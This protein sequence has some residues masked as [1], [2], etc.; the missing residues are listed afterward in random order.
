LSGL[1]LGVAER[2]PYRTI[3][4]VKVRP[5]F[6]ASPDR[7]RWVE[8]DIDFPNSGMLGWWQPPAE[9][10]Q[11]KAW[12][13]Q[14]EEST[15]FDSTKD[16][17]DLYF[18]RTPASP[19]YELIDFVHLA[20]PEDIRLCL[21]KEG[22]PASQCTTRSLIFR[23][24]NG[25]LLGPLEL[26][27]REDRLL[28]EPRETPAQLAEM[29]KKLELTT[30]ANHV[31]MPPKFFLTKVGELDLSSDVLF[32][33]RMLRESR[34]VGSALL[35]RAKL[36][37]KQIS[38]FCS[39][40]ETLPLNTS[41]Q[42]R[43]RRLGQVARD[44]K[45]HI[46]LQEDGLDAL[47]SIPDVGVAIEQEKQKAR[48]AVLEERNAEVEAL[49]E[50]RK[51]L[52]SENEELEQKAA[53]L[54]AEILSEGTR[55]TQIHAQFKRSIAESFQ[56]A[57]DNAGNFLGNVALIKAAVGASPDLK[58]VRSDWSQR[59]AISKSLKAEDVL[60][61]LNDCFSRNALDPDG[62]IA[63]MSSWASG[64]VPIL[65]GDLATDCLNCVFD[66]LTGG[67][68]LVLSIPPALTAVSDLG[69]LSGRSRNGYGSLA[70]FLERVSSDDSLAIVVLEGLNLCQI[71]NAV[72]PLLSDLSC[73]D[74]NQ[75]SRTSSGYKH[76]RL[77]AWPRN[78]L[79]AATFVPSALSMPKSR[80]IWQHCSLISPK[81]KSVAR[82]DA[83]GLELKSINAIEWRRWVSSA[84]S[85]S[86]SPMKILAKYICAKTMASSSYERSMAAFA[87]ALDKNLD[88]PDQ[89]K[90]RV[91][92]RSAILPVLVTSQRDAR[93]LLAGAPLELNEADRD[94]V[95]V[96]EILDNS[97][98]QNG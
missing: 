57:E 27:L 91:L 51:Q 59:A 42:Q 22:I 9:A 61:A 21:T 96:I 48:Q 54:N 37:E 1:F 50:K 85:S 34:D 3:P 30:W 60:Q 53:R 92:L 16:S 44:L 26:V 90:L 39:V 10:D 65:E 63:L 98:P 43:L 74:H 13:F 28:L 15:T 7:T 18:V 35:D 8:P 45:E 5:L 81:R 6:Q 14:T 4:P 47:L 24:A 46:S 69:N 38:A 83:S 73:G 36:T 75:T 23:C 25:T 71:D 79:I 78:L 94:I 56:D 87:S 82:Q 29:P 52:T 31:F 93:A 70:S 95:E 32:V 77:G 68:S 86:D 33:K 20:E 49:G 19:A 2:S 97:V 80:Q 67:E 84:I 66:T 11:F 58:E 64:F 41:R 40:L 89:Q 76:T 12:T 72:L 62:S 17:H 55:L 88:A